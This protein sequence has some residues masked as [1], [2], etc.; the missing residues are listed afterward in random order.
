MKLSQLMPFNE[1]RFDSCMAL[2]SSKHNQ[3]LTQYDMVKLHVMT[4][5]FHTL[6][7]GKPV[8]GGPL[9]RWPRGPVVK[10]AYN[11]VRHWGHE[12]D[13]ND[14][15]PDLFR[16]LR[17][18]NKSFYFKP[19]VSVGQDE[20]SP[21][22]LTAMEEAWKAVM[23]KDWSGS[24][25]F[26]HDDSTFVGRAWKA[27]GGDGTPIDWRDVVRAYQATHPEYKIADEIIALISL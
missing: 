5:I 15:Q 20:F 17:K 6:K 10:E 4:D 23:T 12:W 7:H 3:E 27:A 21:S 2:L 22:E 16:I 24:Q 18:K 26:F 19:I 13:K 14:A 25:K 8:I 1:H 9:S 11:R